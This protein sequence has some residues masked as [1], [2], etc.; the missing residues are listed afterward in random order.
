M[1]GHDT[2]AHGSLN[3]WEWYDPPIESLACCNADVATARLP[4]TDLDEAS[5]SKDA[6]ALSTGT[7]I[8]LITGSDGVARTD[9]KSGTYMVPEYSTLSGY[10]NTVHAH[11]V[12]DD[13]S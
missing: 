3:V 6:N 4:D 5:C 12:L 8:L 10:C 11:G 1:V 9:D 7:N 2:L 13:I